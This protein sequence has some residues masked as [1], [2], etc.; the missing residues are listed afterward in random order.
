MRVIDTTP[1]VGEGRGPDGSPVPLP[2]YDIRTSLIEI[3]FLPSLQLGARQALERD[4]LA[5]KIKACE[6]SD[7]LLE[8]AEYQQI[9]SAVNGFKGYGRND[10]EFVRRVLEA[11][12]VEN[13]NL[14]VV[15]DKGGA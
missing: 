1:Y 9:E 14:K 11:K 13:R 15:G 8:D 5:R 10:V 7:L 6:G 4:D 3:L 2:P 12:K